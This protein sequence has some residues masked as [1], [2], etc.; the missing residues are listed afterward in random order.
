MKTIVRNNMRRYL[1]LTAFAMIALLVTTINQSCTDLDEELFDS[2][3]PENFFKS[4]EEFISALGAAYTQFS[5]Y[6]SNDPF[7]ID[8]LMTDEGV[9]PTRG[10][11]W[12]DGGVLR[13]AHLHSYGF[14]DGHFN[15]GWNF[16]FGGVNTANRLIYQFQSLVESGE[17]EQAA[18]DEIADRHSGEVAGQDRGD[19]LGGVAEDQHQLPGPDDLVRQTGSAGQHEDRDDRRLVAPHVHSP[20]AEFRRTL[21]AGHG[22]SPARWYPPARVCPP[23]TA[24]ATSENR[25]ARAP[26]S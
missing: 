1:R 12:D 7:A 18:A 9:Y 23:Q 15:G 20:V 22:T 19:G 16:G 4:Q 10:Q 11:D 5:D 6:A 8:E 25:T 26:S 24:A 2:V 17:V 13:R 21:P 3:T 14:E